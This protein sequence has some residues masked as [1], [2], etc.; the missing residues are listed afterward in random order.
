MKSPKVS[1]II[2]VYNAEK[3]IGGILKKL[4]NQSY[5]N[6]EV[7]VVNDGSKDDSLKVVKSIS[8]K[9]RRI[10]VVD[11]ENAGVSVARNVGIN[12]STG[13]FITFIDA[14]DDFSEDLINELVTASFDDADFVMC[15]MSING[16]RITSRGLI[17]EGRKSIVSYVLGSL[18]MKNLFYGPCCKLFRRSTIAKFSIEF[19]ESIKYGEDTIFV[20][21]YLRH[22]DRLVILNKPLYLYSFG[23]FGLASANS[24]NKSFLVA[25]NRALDR[26]ISGGLSAKSTLL[27]ILVRFRW[28]LALV[29]NK[30]GVI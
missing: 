21:N 17:V 7:V 22:V 25:R 13:E 27:Y 24:A 2:P 15:G 30:L 8:M 3:T 11:Q 6:I 12:N 9:D 20:L 10:L 14:D 18:L 1:V 5:M 28:A 16:K 19:P 29:K 4:I 23:P 26:F